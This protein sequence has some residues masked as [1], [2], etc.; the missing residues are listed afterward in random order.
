MDCIFC[1]IIKKQVP[2]DIVYEDDVLIVFKDIKPSAPIHLL[3]APK[4][5]IESV[6]KAKEEDKGLLID[7]MWRGK[8]L[9]QEKGLS[10]MGYKLIFNCGR[11]GGQ[12]IDHI[13]LHLMGGWENKNF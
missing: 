11:G 1:K 3:I 9:A 4:K 7:M 13:H 2:S 10:K 12:I 6:I 8:I 5:H